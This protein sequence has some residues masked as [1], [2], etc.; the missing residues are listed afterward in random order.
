LET[1]ILILPEWL[2]ANGEKEDILDE[3]E[4]EDLREGVVRPEMRNLAPCA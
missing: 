2:E 1:T 3:G 4:G